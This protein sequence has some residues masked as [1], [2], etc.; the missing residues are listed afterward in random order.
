MTTNP[1]LRSLIRVAVLCAGTALG[2]VLSEV[3][4]ADR[5]TEWEMRSR[6][7]VHTHLPELAANPPHVVI[8]DWPRCV[9]CHHNCA[10]AI[11]Q[12]CPNVPLVLIG[13]DPKSAN[14][15]PQIGLGLAAFVPKT[16]PGD[17][18]IAEPLR[19]ALLHCA[20][21]AG[22]EEAREGLARMALG[23]DSLR[24]RLRGEWPR[25]DSQT[26]AD[27][28][29]RAVLSYLANPRQLDQAKGQSLPGW[30][31]LLAW[32]RLDD[33]M[34]GGISLDAPGHYRR[35]VEPPVGVDAEAW[36]DALRPTTGDVVSH[37]CAADVLSELVRHLEPPDRII[38]ALRLREYTNR[39]IAER[40]G[41]SPSTV[42][43]ALRRIAGAARRLRR[44]G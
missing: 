16:T 22:A 1:K 40:T 30:L 17:Q 4:E 18:P 31:L 38:L 11:H 27:A 34:R 13:A 5:Q 28:I 24:D 20:V 42:Q 36:I 21:C 37:V 6:D 26:I 44:G 32:R 9:S 15:P 39:E 2:G 14:L 8:L 10:L 35:R 41:H 33:L 29:E 25:A 43:E 19:W 7:E 3:R 23:N 12:S